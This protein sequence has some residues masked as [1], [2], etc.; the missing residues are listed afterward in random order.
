VA[1]DSFARFVVD[2]LRQLGG[3]CSR[4]MF[5]GFGLYQGERFFGIIADGRLFLKVDD[6]TRPEFAA[7]GMEPFR[8]NARQ[9]MQNYYEAPASVV[10]DPELLAEWARRAAAI[11]GTA[12]RRRSRTPCGLKE[13]R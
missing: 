10:D 9:V 7:H 1:D 13:Q 2:Q 12:T 5:G 4:A 3:V 11:E 6:R 8:P